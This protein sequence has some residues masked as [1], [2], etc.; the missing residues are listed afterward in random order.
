[1]KMR[2]AE[3]FAY[4]EPQFC[5]L[6]NKIKQDFLKFTSKRTIHC[7]LK[8]KN[9]PIFLLDRLQVLQ[10]PAMVCLVHNDVI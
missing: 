2:S 1:M 9:S 10:N 6:K 5:R 8:L 7:V 4:E 3:N